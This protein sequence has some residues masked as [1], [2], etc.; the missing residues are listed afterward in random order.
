MFKNKYLYCVVGCMLA[1]SAAA[2]TPYPQRPIRMILPF[3]PGGAGD[4]V[5]RILQPR[6]TE[7]LGQQ[8]IVDNRPGASGN[9]GVEVAANANA[10][11]YTILLS[12]IGAMA[13]NPNLYKSFPVKPLRDF[14]AV[15]QV[16][17]PPHRP[18]QSGEH[19]SYRERCAR[20][21][22]AFRR[23]LSDLLSGSPGCPIRYPMRQPS[24]CECC[25]SGYASASIRRAC[26]CE[27]RT[28]RG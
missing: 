8:V 21:S 3:A 10:D 25:R 27:T 1:A 26:S 4:F 7:L 24:L 23:R 14:V 13:I 22:K 16:V 18:P 17:F 20:F 12:N 15:S 5:A 2:Q 9:L 19:R 6:M 11:G 28:K